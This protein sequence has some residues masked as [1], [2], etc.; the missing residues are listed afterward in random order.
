MHRLIEPTEENKMA[1]TVRV[2]GPLRNFTSGLAEVQIEATDVKSLFDELNKNHDGF[3]DRICQ[4]DGSVSRFVN[5]YVNDQDIRFLSDLQ[6]PLKPGD[7]V[8][9]IPA[10]AG[11]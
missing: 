4:P 11:G 1:V 2:P 8:S 10:I 7:Q 9:I 5:I 3:K 6:T